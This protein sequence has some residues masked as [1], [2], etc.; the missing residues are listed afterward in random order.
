MTDVLRFF[1]KEE[2]AALA[3]IA[4]KLRAAEKIAVITHMRPDGDAFGSA[5]ALVSALKA[6][7]KDCA[8]CD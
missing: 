3:R 4:E 8:V 2:R 6:L 7:G 5:L 1:N